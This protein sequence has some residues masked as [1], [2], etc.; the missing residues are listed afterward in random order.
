MLELAPAQAIARHIPALGLYVHVPFCVST[1][2]FCAFYQTKPTAAGVR[3]FLAGVAR[4]AELAGVDRP[5]ETMFWGGGTPGLLSPRALTEL[6][7]GLARRGGG[8]LRE[9]SVEMSPG[10]VTPERLGALRAMGVTRISLGVQS[11]QPAYGATGAAGLCRGARRRFRE[12]QPR[13]HLRDPRPGTGGMARRSRR[14][15]PAGARSP[16]HL[17]PDV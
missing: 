4:E 13:P 6:G 15:D 10:S 16:L 17:L 8:R 3:R 14:G 5:V 9:W 11:F 2:D 1:C 12:R 7:T